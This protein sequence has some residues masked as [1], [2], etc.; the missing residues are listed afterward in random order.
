[1][2]YDTPN[3]HPY[4]D[5]RGLTRNATEVL[6]CP[7]AWILLGW[8]LLDGTKPAKNEYQGTQSYY[9]QRSS[10][11]LKLVARTA[12]PS[13]SRHPSCGPTWSRSLAIII[14]VLITNGWILTTCSIQGLK[15]IQKNVAGH[16]LFGVFFHEHIISISQISYY[17]Q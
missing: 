9:L 4:I 6:S 13:F 2:R 11:S 8:R 7:D 14:Q 16:S 10:N 17:L 3:L 1:M 5:I 15:F 12:L